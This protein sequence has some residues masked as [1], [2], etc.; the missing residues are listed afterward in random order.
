MSRI[1]NLFKRSNNSPT[2]SGPSVI[3]GPMDVS[4]NTHVALN[5][6]TGAL[7]GLPEPWLKML[8]KELT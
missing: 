4:H 6:Q 2:D 3:S 8:N 7:E 5:K 1:K